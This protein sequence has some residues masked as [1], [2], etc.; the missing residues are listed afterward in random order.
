LGHFASA[1][2]HRYASAAVLGPFLYQQIIYM[3]FFGW[4]MFDQIPDLMVVTGA[5]L[6]VASGLFLLR[7]EFRSRTA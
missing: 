4:L 1:M 5:L 6:V 3:T 7:Q 2:A